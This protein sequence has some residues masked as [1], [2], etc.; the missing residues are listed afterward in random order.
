MTRVLLTI[1][2]AVCLVALNAGAAQSQ[3]APLPAGTPFTVS[4]DTY[5]DS[6]APTSNFGTGDE[7][8]AAATR[9][10]YLRF[11][12]S[13]L[14]GSVARATLRLRADDDA[15]RGFEVRRLDAA[16]G[17]LTL[18][19]A[20]APAPA[21]TPVVSSGGFDSGFINVDVTPLVTSG[22]PVSLVLSSPHEALT[23]R[24]R[25]DGKPAQ[26]FVETG[27]APPG[28]TPGSPGTPGTPLPST[29]NV[30]TRDFSFT[31]SRLE[32]A[33]GSVTVNVTNAGQDVHT[34]TAVGLGSVT[35]NP[36]ET[37]SV[38]FLASPG[39]YD[40]FC[41]VGS[42]ADKGMR[43]TLIASG[44][45]PPPGGGTPPPPPP[46]PS[47]PPPP[48]PPPAGTP[49]PTSASVTAREFSFAPSALTVAAGTVT[50]T[51][52]NEGQL[53]HTFTIDGLVEVSLAAG[54]RKTVTFTAAPGSYRFYCAVSGHAAI[55]MEGTLV[56]SSGGA[57]PAGGPPPPP[58]VA[59][60]PSPPPP[61]APAAPA[62]G[63]SLP[64][65]ATVSATEFA[66]APNALAVAAGT[67]TLTVTNDG[68]LPHTFTIDGLVDVSLAAG[69]R[70][71]VTFT[72]APGSYRF[73][74][75]V[76]GHATIGMAGT[77]SVGAS[78]AGGAAPPGA[79]GATGAAGGHDHAGHVAPEAAFDARLAGAKRG[80]T[81][82]S[83]S[84]AQRTVR[85]AANR[86]ERLWAFGEGRLRPLV[87]R[88]RQ[89]ATV[90]FA[91]RNSGPRTAALRFGW[92][93]AGRAVSV[94]SGR[95]ALVVFRALR[96]GVYAVRGASAATSSLF[97]VVVVEPRAGWW[98]GAPK[99]ARTYVLVQNEV[100]T[101][102]A[103]PQLL[104]FN[105]FAG[106]YVDAP[107]AV[108]ANERVRLF[109]VNA[110]LRASTAFSVASTRFDRIWSARPRAAAR[111]LVL[112]PGRGGVVEFKATGAGVRPFV[113]RAAALPLE[114]RGAFSIAGAPAA[115][116]G[117]AASAKITARDLFYEPKTLRV[118]AGRVAL[119][120]VNAGK[121]PH[122]FTVTGIANVRAGAGKTVTRQ[123]DVKPGTYQIFCAEPGH[124]TAGMIGT[125]VAA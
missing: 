104:A 95:S 21:A 111:Q 45:A 80:V 82:V 115:P 36:G 91:L 123:F 98:R 117:S 61:G 54:E 108:T 46:P 35:V 74:C 84:L 42:H 14:S 29:V 102:G 99:P 87:V 24:S 122:T 41:A 27:A 15:A 100:Y 79:N 44:Q 31:P 19:D 103:T 67:V 60:P 1:L 28:G 66:F 112:A 78:G 59:P 16:W 12:L 22:G 89:G 86:Q 88:V 113:S 69:E 110:G 34:W 9:R 107:L 114:A 106:Q 72:A 11:D 20:H 65:S 124:K 39:T 33:A 18:T 93:P 76:S 63:A 96:P 109:V 58:P 81:S 92:M 50:V 64:S 32:V 47:S 38:T 17:E 101:Q 120:F 121:L 116:A 71:T 37:K 5:V 85:F 30:T 57:P 125:L 25:E 105:G 73:Y 56:A 6:L 2:T 7:L 75:A 48:T 10:T 70:K 68:R 77:L 62:P 94:R 26:L 40:F 97:G 49:L 52:T 119:T 55:G 118:K 13:G 4:A 8:F 53:P 51:V 3:D 23:F 83:L 90:R 43:G